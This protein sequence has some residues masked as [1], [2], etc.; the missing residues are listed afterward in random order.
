MTYAI[1]SV[2]RSKGL[3]DKLVVIGPGSSFMSWEDEFEA[4]FGKKVTSLR[5]RGDIVREMEDSFKKSDLMLLTYQMASR[6]TPEL[7]RLLSNSK[8]LL[9]LD[10]SH[11]IKRFN[12][13]LWSSSV[14]KLAPY[15]T[16]R[17]ILTG[18]PMPNN[19]YDLWSQ[20]TFLWPFKN[21]LKNS[22]Q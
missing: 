6:I 21:L 5:V 9:V 11:N 3:L 7:I 17:M 14:L 2:L 18:T 12:G 19:L 20:F 22:G 10:E 4:C 16:K 15:A 1:Y 13:G 8:V